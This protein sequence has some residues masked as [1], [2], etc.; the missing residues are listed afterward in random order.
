MKIYLIMLAFGLI[1]GILALC[2]TIGECKATF[3][4]VTDTKPI[5]MKQ[6][7]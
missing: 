4:F 7:I 1:V 2:H 6:E 3:T 5:F